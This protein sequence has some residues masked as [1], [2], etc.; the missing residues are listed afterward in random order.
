MTHFSAIPRGSPASSET[1]CCLA[2]RCTHER[3]TSVVTTITSA[4]HLRGSRRHRRRSS[5]WRGGSAV[6]PVVHFCL[7]RVRCE[8]RVRLY[9]DR[10]PHARLPC[11]GPRRAGG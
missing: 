10:Q 9:P 6:T 4:R 8:T 5:S 3:Q 1:C 11:T 2:P 7:R